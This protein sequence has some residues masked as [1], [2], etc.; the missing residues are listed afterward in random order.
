MLK[1]DTEG[2]LDKVKETMDACGFR[3]KVHENIQQ[4]IWNKLFVNV[5]LSAVTVVLNVKM[6][7]IAEN[8][9]A[10]AM[11]AQLLH[12]AVTVAQ[13]L[14]LEADEAHLLQEIRE[15]SMRVPEGVTSICA[16][17]SNGRRTEV[18]TIS[19]SVIRAAKKVGV[20]VPAH[21]FLVNMVHAMEERAL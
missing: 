18:D 10:S 19:G 20:P 5:A 4:L 12:E 21:E 11:S 3:A 2:M 14:G 9:H 6:G 15:T 8:A 7:Y 13:A 16:D 17:L 1:P